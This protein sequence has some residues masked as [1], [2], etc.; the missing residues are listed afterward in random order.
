MMNYC[1]GFLFSEDRERVLLIEKNQRTWQA[2]KV[3]GIGGKVELGESNEDAMRRECHE[4]IG[5]EVPWWHEFGHF[6]FGKPGTIA[7]STIFCFAATG[8]I[9]SA[10]QCTDEKIFIVPS[11]ALPPHSLY[12]LHW[13]V[14]MAK[15]YL[16]T[17]ERPLRADYT[18]RL[19]TSI[20][21]TL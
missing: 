12:N 11:S 5:L 8:D 18:E 1:L 13:L 7:D 9:D 2:G 19:T 15:H 10:I 20:P 14:P 16:E 6:S 4:E 17:F 21:V 3:N